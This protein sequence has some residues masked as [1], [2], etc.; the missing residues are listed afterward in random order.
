MHGIIEIGKCCPD[1]SDFIWIEILSD[2]QVMNIIH[3]IL[4]KFLFRGRSD[5]DYSHKSY[6]PFSHPTTKLI[7]GKNLSGR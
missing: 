6:M 7:M 5:S 2:L 1:E 3:K 4:D